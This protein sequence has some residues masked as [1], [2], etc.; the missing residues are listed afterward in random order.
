MRSTSKTFSLKVGTLSFV[1]AVCLG[2][3]AIHAWQAREAEETPAAAADGYIWALHNSAHLDN[4]PVQPAED[5][6]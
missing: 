4:L 5:S 1:L 2:A 3:T 6:N